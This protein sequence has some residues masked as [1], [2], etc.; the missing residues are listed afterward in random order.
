MVY[1]VVRCEIRND[2]TLK[3]GKRS[4]IISWPIRLRIGG[5]YFLEGGKLYYIIDEEVQNGKEK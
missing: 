4:K 2:G 5:L 1:K 3:T